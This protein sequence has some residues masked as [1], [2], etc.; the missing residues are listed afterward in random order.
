MVFNAPYYDL[1][2]TRCCK[3]LLL[4]SFLTINAQWFDWTLLNIDGFSWKN[5]HP[6]KNKELIELRN[7]KY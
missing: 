4:I 7:S 3:I 2:F 5:I 6:Q 1:E